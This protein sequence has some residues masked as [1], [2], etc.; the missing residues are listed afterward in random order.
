M[1]TL[2]GMIFAVKMM[3]SAHFLYLALAG[4]PVRGTFGRAAPP[5]ARA[6]RG[7]LAFGAL[8]RG[9]G[10][11]ILRSSLDRLRTIFE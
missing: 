10:V 11:R 8:K 4:A 9:G 7:R 3:K 6:A 1:K 2:V 5:A